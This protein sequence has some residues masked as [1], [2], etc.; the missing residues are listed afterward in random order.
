MTQKTRRLLAVYIVWIMIHFAFL[1][2]GSVFLQRSC[3]QVEYSSY[4]FTKFVF[5]G[6]AYDIT[7][8]LFY[9]LIPFG[10]Y[11]V[12]RLWRNKDDNNICNDRVKSIPKSDNGKIINNDNFKP[13]I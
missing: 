13:L 5:V 7:E 10:C 9:T 11:W 6:E 8:F 4:R 12:I 2:V 3:I 1:T